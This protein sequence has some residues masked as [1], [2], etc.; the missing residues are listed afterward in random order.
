MTLSSCVLLLKISVRSQCFKLECTAK[1]S[2]VKPLIQI[3]FSLKNLLSLYFYKRFQVGCI[4]HL[5]Y[6]DSQKQRDL[7]S[8]LLGPIQILYLLYN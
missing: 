5:L 2:I 3:S 8:I 1:M 6:W 7:I 4:V